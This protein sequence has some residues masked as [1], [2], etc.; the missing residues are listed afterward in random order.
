MGNINCGPV[1]IARHTRSSH[2]AFGY[3]ISHVRRIS[4]EKYR[5]E[6]THLS[7]SIAQPSKTYDIP[8]LHVYQIHG[9]VLRL[10]KPHWM[11]NLIDYDR[12]L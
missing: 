8:A 11:E 4:Y 5:F 1:F 10:Q 6:N 12:H 7:G 2:S 9:F 3:Y